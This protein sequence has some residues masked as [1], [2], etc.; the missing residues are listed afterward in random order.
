MAKVTGKKSTKTAAKRHVKKAVV[1]GRR[2]ARNSR[3]SS[4]FI[5][6]VV[7][8][9]SAYVA[10]NLYPAGMSGLMKLNPKNDDGSDLIPRP[11]VGGVA[12]FGLDV[13]YRLLLGGSF[14]KIADSAA[15]G[16][17]GA[18]G[19]DHNLLARWGILQKLGLNDYI[20]EYIGAPRLPAGS[21]RILV[22]GRGVND[23]SDVADIARRHHHHPEHAYR[24]LSDVGE[25]GS[26]F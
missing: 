14:P 11:L 21:E 2:N 8:S 23:V 25:P 22:R 12:A 15:K 1:K 3:G 26:N 20:G 13:L 16:T 9:G 18:L 10:G 4:T 24:R 6:T 17:W 7:E 5:G 19:A